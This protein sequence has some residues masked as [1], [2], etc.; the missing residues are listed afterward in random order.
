MVEVNSALLDLM[1]DKVFDLFQDTDCDIDLSFTYD[2]LAVRSQ[3][4]FNAGWASGGGL[5]KPKP[6][7]NWEWIPLLWAVAT[8]KQ[9]GRPGVVLMECGAGWGPWIVRGHAAAR[10][11]GIDPIHIIGVEAEAHHFGYMQAHFADNGVTAAEGRAVKGIVA[12]QTGIALF[13][14]STDPSRQW[15]LRA[16]GKA[17]PDRG[18]LLAELA[19]QPIDGKPGIFKVG[20][21]PAEY[22]L[23]DA[24]GLT[25]LMGNHPVVDFIHFDIQGAE[26]DVI[27]A[28]IA[29]MDKRVRCIAVGTHSGEIEARL[30]VLLAEHEWHCVHD[31][32]QKPR[33]NG[34]LGDG[35][36]VWVNPRFL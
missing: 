15:G 34:I 4:G 11:L 10:Q 14:I 8:A 25:D 9:T 27:E 30:R 18:K 3:L 22:V 32:V 23:V 5:K 13:P 1:S 2:F 17:G 19:A 21:Y 20:K 16:L 7:G 35:N 31:E 36:Q 33:P 6:K 26:A 12:A 28:A 24:Y 29:D